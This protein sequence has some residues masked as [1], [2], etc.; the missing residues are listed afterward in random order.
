MYDL[1]SRDLALLWA[2]PLVYVLAYVPLCRALVR[3]KRI[4]AAVLSCRSAHNVLMAVY[5]AAALA[6]S[7]WELS[8]RPLTPY[9]LL[10]QP[11]TPAPLLV[12]TWYASKF[13]EWV[14]TALLLAAGKSL[15]ALHYNHHLTTATVVASHFVGRD[16]RTSI[17]DVPLFL[18]ALVHTLM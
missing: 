16:V 7:I 1:T 13:V 9:G 18:N 14:D 6:G 10:C 2:P 3:H 11:V 15:S 17:F 8:A 4:A 12:K 5:S